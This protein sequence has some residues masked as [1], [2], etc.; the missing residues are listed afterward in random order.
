MAPETQYFEFAGGT[1][2][3]FKQFSTNALAVLVPKGP[4]QLRID[5]YKDVAVVGRTDS[6][7]IVIAHRNVSK[8][9]AE[10]SR[11]NGQWYLRDVASTNGTYLNGTRMTTD[12]VP[13]NMGDTVAFGDQA[14]TFTLPDASP[15]KQEPVQAPVAQGKGMTAMFQ[16]LF[17]QTNQAGGGQG[18]GGHQ[19]APPMAAPAQGAPVGATMMVKFSDAMTD[20]YAQ[21][22]EKSLTPKT[23]DL[24]AIR[25]RFG[26]EPSCDI[27][28]SD[29]SVKG[30]H[31][32]IV[33]EADGRAKV[34]TLSPDYLIKVNGEPL[35]MQYLRDM[36]TI[37][38]GDVVFTYRLLKF[39]DAKL[40]APVSSG[41]NKGSST[42][43][44]L[45]LV[46]LLV[47]GGG[48]AYVKFG[49]LDKQETVLEET[50][51][52]DATPPPNEKTELDII[53]DLWLRTQTVEANT[54][55]LKMDQSQPGV[56][57]LATAIDVSIKTD[58]LLGKERILEARNQVQRMIGNKYEEELPIVRLKDKIALA[59]ENKAR[60]DFQ[61]AEREYRSGRY[62]TA[63]DLYIAA[64]K[65]KPGFTFQG[66]KA[67]DL[68]EGARLA[69]LA[70]KQMEQWIELCRQELFVEAADAINIAMTDYNAAPTVD[71]IEKTRAA[72]MPKLQDAYNYA[73][74]MA[75]YFSGDANTSMSYYTKIS[76]GFKNEE[77]LGPRAEKIEKVGKLALEA[78]Q[79]QDLQLA[80]EVLG[81]ETNPKNAY[82]V[83]MSQLKDNLAAVQREQAQGFLDLGKDFITKGEDAN[84]LAAFF[85]S[86]QSDRTF[87][88][89]GK[90]H[91]DMA[92]KI[93]NDAYTRGTR[94]EDR[95]WKIDMY[96]WI[97]QN[98]FNTD[99]VYTRAQ[100]QLTTMGV[101]TS[102]ATPV[103][104]P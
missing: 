28:I 79:K 91:D 20:V 73:Q 88:A 94:P 78:A 9:H 36:D 33:F 60:T 37:Q 19:A 103:P 55:V 71:G 12:P 21:L 56:S 84:A 100:N 76:D 58:E 16:D 39:P 63:K 66:G 95:Q 32:E 104:T 46:I 22:V 81:L 96:Q 45:A 1:D 75:S 50:Q 18:G 43:T 61:R 6:T 2:D 48:L 13:V 17:A 26:S 69:E 30:Q 51:K 35:R 24:V 29:S 47:V 41:A 83:Q 65:L 102:T 86:R 87:E 40:L 80:L 59:E 99:T 68:A 15:G 54:R 34:R 89:A 97:M 5:I 70:T 101:L 74:M 52:A 49:I 93:L 98:S 27:V 8:R 53:R 11:Q 7:D 62:N 14:Y 31:G 82:Y 57:D 25:N 42:K 77:R 67:L 92:N 85:K 23:H 3:P 64:D 44:L 72:F 4:G 10:L 38:V 90:A